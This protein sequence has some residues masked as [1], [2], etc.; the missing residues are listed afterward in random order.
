MYV[1]GGEI[2]CKIGDRVIVER[3]ALGLR[4]RCRLGGE[5]LG[6]PGDHLG[7]DR[8]V[9]GQPSSRPGEIT[10]PL[11]STMRAAIPA[12]RSASAQSRSQPPLA[13]STASATPL[14]P[15]QVIIRRQPSPVLGCDSR[16]R[17][18]RMHASACRLDTSM[19]TILSPC[20]ILPLPSLLVRALAPKQL[21]GLKGRHRSCPSL[22]LRVRL[23]DTP[24]QLQRR[25]VAAQPP[26]RTFRPIIQ[27]QG[28]IPTPRPGPRTRIY[29]DPSHFARDWQG[30]SSTMTAAVM[31]QNSMKFGLFGGARARGGPAGDSEG[32]HD[33]IRYVVAA[34]E[35]GFS[36]VF[37]VEH[38]FTG[39]G[40]V[41]A[42]LNL[43]ELPR[44]AHRED[45]PRHRRR[46]AAVAQPGAG[47]RGGRDARPAVE[48]AARFRRRQGLSALRILRLLH[49]AGR[50]DRALRRG[51]RR[52]PQ[53]VDQ[54]GPVLLRGHLVA[55]RQHRR[56]A[57]PDPA[58]A[59]AVMAGR[60]QRPSRSAARRARATTCCSTR[61]RPST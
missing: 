9:L 55:L 32:Y 14:S 33:F 24:A 34:E 12:W 48:R 58:A 61:S 42:S 45:P 28:V 44:G 38:H 2:T 56:R 26:V 50:G 36:S 31:E 54:Q 39:F 41:S 8:I 37:L 17:S 3:R 7:V 22:S 4:G 60:R 19:P 57:G 21:F 25:A 5:G 53:G 40:Q 43:L 18:E 29:V 20:A 51:D 47:R 13:S 1:L 27:T 6:E 16:S 11:G 15:Y 23:R 52:D 49:P 35:L 10:H 59:P 46:R 30:R